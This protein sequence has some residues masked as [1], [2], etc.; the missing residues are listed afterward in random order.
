M[1]TK[2]VEVKFS[3]VNI[4]SEM[5]RPRMN[6]MAATDEMRQTKLNVTL[7]IF[8]FDDF[9]DKFIWSSS[10][11]V[12]LQSLLSSPKR[13][14][15]STTSG[16]EWSNKLK[17]L[18]SSNSLSVSVRDLF[19]LF[20]CFFKYTKKTE[21]EQESRGGHTRILPQGRWNW[22]SLRGFRW[23]CKKTH[24]R[25]WD[26]KSIKNYKTKSIDSKADCK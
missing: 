18:F 11:I 25:R 10:I 15:T 2:T 12:S 5:R 6:K 22:L 21:K 23:T 14:C 9:P 17:F 8:H 16:D 24:L 20:F 19:F 4:D 26:C 13:K 7:F 1:P 3:N